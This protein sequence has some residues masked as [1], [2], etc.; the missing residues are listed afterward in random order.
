[1]IIQEVVFLPII[2]SPAQAHV[3]IIPDMTS[4]SG[5]GGIHKIEEDQAKILQKSL[6]MAEW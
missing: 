4:K 3:H 6:W 1:M 2:A 5:R